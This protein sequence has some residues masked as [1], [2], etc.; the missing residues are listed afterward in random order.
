MQV[1]AQLAAR[2]EDVHIDNGNLRSLAD[3]GGDDS[4]QRVVESLDVGV[5]TRLLRW[6][7][8]GHNDN[9]IGNCLQ[10]VVEQKSK[11]SWRI[12][13]RLRRRVSSVQVVGTGVQQHDVGL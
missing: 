9:S 12:G 5:K 11:S 1:I 2:A 6:D 4:R 13:I 10:N 3:P 7:D 8:L